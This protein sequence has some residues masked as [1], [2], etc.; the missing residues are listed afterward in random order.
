MSPVIVPIKNSPDHLKVHFFPD[1]VRLRA[2]L[3]RFAWR[4]RSGIGWRT[5]LARFKP[6]ARKPPRRKWPK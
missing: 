6:T 1:H 4:G 5:P 2:A 3:V